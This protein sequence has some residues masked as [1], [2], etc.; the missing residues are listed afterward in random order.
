M[1]TNAT[2]VRSILE[3]YPNVKMVFTGQ[4]HGMDI[5][6]K[7]GVIYVATSA[8]VEYPNAYRI[9]E[10]GKKGADTI[11]VKLN[12]AQISNKQL[13]EKSRLRMSTEIAALRLGSEDDRVRIFEFERRGK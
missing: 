3:S 10:V 1:P 7:N 9:V 2:E 13:V 11:Y 12:W 8:L 6:E 5:K 4:H